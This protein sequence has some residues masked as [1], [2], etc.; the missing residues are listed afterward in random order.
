MW[1]TCPLLRAQTDISDLLGLRWTCCHWARELHTHPLAF[2]PISCHFHT[3][4]FPPP[5]PQFIKEQKILLLEITLTFSAHGTPLQ[6]V[7]IGLQPPQATPWVSSFWQETSNH[8]AIMQ[9]RGYTTVMI[10]CELKMVDASLA[11]EIS[12][13]ARALPCLLSGSEGATGRT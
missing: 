11:S 1:N 4:T 12:P 13:E 2:R 9:N 10:M 5:S 7:G 6:Q 8:W 3:V